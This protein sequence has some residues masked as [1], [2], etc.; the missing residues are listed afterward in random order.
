[1]EKPPDYS[2]KKLS[3]Q[4]LL[5]QF[6]EKIDTLCTFLVSARK[7]Q[8]EA[9]L[10]VGFLQRRPLLTTTPPTSKEVLLYYY[11]AKVCRLSLCRLMHP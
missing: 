4:G 11:D 9:E 1:M 3:F 7:V 10:G 6:I 5:L 8:K 2:M